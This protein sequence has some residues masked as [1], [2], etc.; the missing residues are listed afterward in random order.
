MDII[1]VVSLLKLFSHIKRE[2]NT[3]SS[4]FIFILINVSV[5]F[6]QPFSRKHY[7]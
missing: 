7:I 1:I 3:S 2:L 5:D 6:Q 4:N